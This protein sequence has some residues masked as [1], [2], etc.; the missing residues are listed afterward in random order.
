MH[1]DKTFARILLILSVVHAA[2]AGP[3]IVR[4]RSLDVDENVTPAWEKRANSGNSAQDLSPV[5]QMDNQLPTTSGTPLSQDVTPPESGTSQPDNGPHPA[6]GAPHLQSVPPP[7]PALGTPQLHDGLSTA[8]GA[9]SVHDGVPSG[10][11]G[12]D[13]SHRFND[14]R[15]TP[16][17]HESEASSSHEPEA[18]SLH[19]PAAAPTDHSISFPMKEKLKF[20]TGSVITTGILA[21]LVFGIPAL[22]SIGNHSY[23][24]AFLN[25]FPADI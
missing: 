18:P 15:Y 23:V 6:S 22:L 21:G 25:P 20:I 11:G 13:E 4:Q 16:S 19:E 3:A 9:S 24:P 1:R 7:G 8:S 17:S 14:F 12:F 10:S 2:A 5:P